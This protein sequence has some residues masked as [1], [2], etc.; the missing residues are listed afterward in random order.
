MLTN[1]FK[2]KDRISLI[3]LIIANLV[4]IVGVIVAGWD[5]GTIV[6][7]YWTENI[8]VGFY[9]V[10]KLALVKTDDSIRREMGRSVISFFCL[11]YGLFCFGHGIFVLL[12]ISMTKGNPDLS[13]LKLLFGQ[14]V[15]PSLGLFVSH[16]VSF[17]ENTLI[18]KEYKSV[19][20][21]QQMKQPY[22]RIVLLHVAILFAMFV[23]MRLGPSVGLLV[24]LIA[25][26]ILLDLWLHNRSHRNLFGGKTESPETPE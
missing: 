6:L 26:K 12:L 5:A 3:A 23:L 16:G 17:V 10:V 15:W 25:G 22:G 11:H 13:R 2:S 14:I 21:R 8:I 1:P 24:A 20:A 4:P 7:L 19:T 9:N 18:H